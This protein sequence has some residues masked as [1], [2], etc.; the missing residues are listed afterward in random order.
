MDHRST[1]TRR[2]GVA[3]ALPLALAMAS[4]AGAQ[5]PEPSMAMAP[6]PAYSIALSG[7]EDGSSVTANEITVD[8]ETIGFT[9][10]CSLAGKPDV[11]GTGHYHTIL[12]G[13]LIDMEC[14][15]SA[16]VS[17]QN[18]APGPHTLIVVP[19]LGNHH[20]IQGGAAMVS[21]EYAPTEALPE[22]VASESTTPPTISVLSPA[23]G[24]EVSGEFTIDVA[25][26][27]F[28]LSEALFGKPDLNGLGHWH[29]N[30]DSTDGPM[31]GMV[32]ML[33]MSGSTSV[34]ASTEGLVPGPHT[35]FAIL[36]SNQHMPFMEP[37]MASVDLIVK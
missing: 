8:V 2:L 33:G 31:M 29:A 9:P 20:E 28:T 26:T 15:P 24:T 4:T 19:A 10:S 22:I 7:L 30:V 34:V 16:T 35:F 17:L 1:W 23:A 11:E 18:V 3:S 13:S 21:F 37:V 32:T 14:T 12:D 25:V 27:D 5:S 6:D 36:V